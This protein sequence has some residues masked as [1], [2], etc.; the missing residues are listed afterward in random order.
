MSLPALQAQVTL[1]DVIRSQ[2]GALCD[3]AACSW[4]G[5]TATRLQAHDAW[6]PR[7]SLHC[8]SCGTSLTVDR[9]LAM[10]AGRT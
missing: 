9:R 1:A 8:H 5:S 3:G 2:S 10:A 4:C 7:A 6:P